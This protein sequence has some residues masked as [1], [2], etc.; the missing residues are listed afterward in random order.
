LLEIRNLV[1]RFAEK[2]ILNGISLVVERG[3]TVAIIGGSGSGKTTLARI[4]VGLEQPTSG[5]VLVDGVDPE[6]LDDEERVAARSRFGVVFQR[7]ALLDS[8][9]VFD[10]VAFPL[11]ET[12]R[13]GEREI[14]ERVLGALTDLG[15]D[16]AA[17]RLPAELSGGM[18]KRVAI[19]RALV[20][21]P[22][23]LVYDEPTSGLDPPTSR[24]VDDLVEHM[25]EQYL[26]TSIV[27]THDM[28][29]AYDVADRVALLAHGE[30][31]AEGAPEVLFRS[32]D[33]VVHAF[34]ESSGVDLTRLGP[35]KRRRSPAEIRQAWQEH[36]DGELLGHGRRIFTWSHTARP[37]HG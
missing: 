9:T 25:R 17:Y 29:T 33:P 6:S 19:A 34:A 10:N 16:H 36:R 20:T 5:V 2:T 37:P 35:R 31:V 11:R 14:R 22:E 32:G 18:A 7:H 28:V 3:E 8:L 30:I 21:H 13:L 12:T 1:K 15:V 23:I 27:I 26:I 4:I 24:V